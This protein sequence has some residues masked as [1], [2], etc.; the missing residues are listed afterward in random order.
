[1]AYA[2]ILNLYKDKTIL[3]FKEV[4]ALEK[5]HGSSAHV[6]YKR[7]LG[8]LS[9]FAGG[10]SQK[11]FE[12]I[13][14]S[15]TLLEAF[16]ALGHDEVTV[17]GEAYGG[18]C[19]KMS[20]T[21]G[22]NLRFVAFDVL[23]GETWL[24]VPAAAEVVQKLGLEFVHYVMIPA[25][26]EALNAERDADSVQAIRNGCGSG[27]MR[28]GI[29]IRPPVEVRLNNGQR[30]CAKHKRAE[31]SETKTPRDVDPIDASKA[32][33][34]S[35]AEEVADEW[36]TG[37]RLRHVLDHLKADGVLD[38]LHPDITNTP[39][40]IRAMLE[41]VRREGDGEI[42]WSKEVERAIKSATSKMFKGL[43]TTIGSENE[44]TRP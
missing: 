15:D 28:E 27:K 31:F 10:T 3:I 9:Y 42:V 14:H 38:D 18:K 44:K 43:V 17:Y 16:S 39:H 22:P 25:T 12:D 35:E 5:V 21:Y 29:V 34:L 8:K 1:M 30:I 2:S 6:S 41:D 20:T 32:L 37:E 33:V 36:V 23:V 7:A 4:Y 40:V 24:S 26:V 11:V 19:Q 13:F